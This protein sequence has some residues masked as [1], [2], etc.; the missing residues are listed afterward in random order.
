MT[1][2][3]IPHRRFCQI[4]LRYHP[5]AP[6]CRAISTA[7]L[8]TNWNRRRVRNLLL[9]FQESRCLPLDSLYVESQRQVSTDVHACKIRLLRH[10]T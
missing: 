3:A 9:D 8:A 7:L 10:D 5:L 1:M 2:L 6:Y 4:R